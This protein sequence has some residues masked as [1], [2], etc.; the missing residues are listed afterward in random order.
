MGLHDSGMC[1]LLGPRFYV[2]VLVLFLSTTTYAMIFD[3]GAMLYNPF[4]ARDIDIPHHAVAGGLRKLAKSLSKEDN[5]PNTM[6]KSETHKEEDLKDI[7]ETETLT[8]A[9]AIKKAMAIN[10][11]QGKN[12]SVLVHS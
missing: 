6:E 5:V 8:F 11:I 3:V 7:S 1:I 9:K 4:G 10:K 2:E 12:R